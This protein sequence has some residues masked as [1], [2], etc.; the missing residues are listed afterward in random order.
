MKG[1]GNIAEMMKQAQKQAQKMQKQM[2]E[3]Q[4]D[5]KERVV[6]A[7]SGGGMVTVHMNGKQEILSIKIDPEVVDPK[8]VQMLEDLILSAV[9]QA[10]KKSQELYQAE[11]GKLTGGLNIPGMQGLLGGGM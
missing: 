10:F 6:E 7:S 2:E 8:D 11:M 1:L 9:S 3:I 5:L 4:N